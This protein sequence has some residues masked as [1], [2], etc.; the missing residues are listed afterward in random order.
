MENAIE[1]V[2]REAQDKEKGILTKIKNSSQSAIEN[3][4]IT[5]LPEKGIA[6]GYLIFLKYG[7]DMM[8]PVED[9]S[10]K[11]NKS[12]KGNSLV[13]HVGN[14]HQS[15]ADYNLGNFVNGEN[16]QPDKK[17]LSKLEEATEESL[18]NHETFSIWNSFDGYIHNNNTVILGPLRGLNRKIY[19]LITKV[20]ANSEK[21]DLDVGDAWGSHITTSRFT[22]EISPDQLGKFSN[23]MKNPSFPNGDVDGDVLFPHSLA[24]G[25]FRADKN[26][27]NL[28]T[29]KEFNL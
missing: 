5:T 9:F 22:E 8:V 12:L 27:F 21:R 28:E 17:V 10:R 24:V 2:Y 14:I 20:K 16:F 4:L 23:L 26:G 29:T 3:G 11:I 15:I 25:F 7:N 18:E 1:K 19:D 6:T 13:Y